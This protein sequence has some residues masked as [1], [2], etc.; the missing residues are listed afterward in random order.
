[1][2]THENSPSPLAAC[3]EAWRYRLIFQA[4]CCRPLTLWERVLSGSE[5][6]G[7]D[8]ARKSDRNHSLGSNFATAYSN[9]SPERVIPILPRVRQLAAL[10][11][12][13]SRDPRTPIHPGE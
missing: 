11:L 3:S 5:K 2:W 9:H 4:G 12:A 7:A 6:P 10:P 1:M 13:A 8:F